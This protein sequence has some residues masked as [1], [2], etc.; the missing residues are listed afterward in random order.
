MNIRIFFTLLFVS[1]VFYYGCKKDVGR[2]FA[3]NYKMSGL[4]YFSAYYPDSARYISSDT[5][6]IT[7]SVVSVTEV[8][9]DTLLVN[10]NP[11]AYQGLKGGLYQFVYQ[12]FVDNDNTLLGF[13]ANDSLYIS[14]YFGT[15]PLHGEETILSGTKIN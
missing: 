2:S 8:N 13:R 11:C 9:S 1:V 3:G 7:D 14:G 5:I 6:Y 12:G 4:R 15:N 10:G